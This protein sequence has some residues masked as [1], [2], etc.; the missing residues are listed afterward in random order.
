MA[1]QVVNKGKPVT[2]VHWTTK[3][4]YDFDPVDEKTVLIR[5]KTNRDS[6]RFVVPTQEGRDIYS[7]LLKKGYEVF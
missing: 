6:R 3:I 4:Q 7:A 2:L 1:I 5:H